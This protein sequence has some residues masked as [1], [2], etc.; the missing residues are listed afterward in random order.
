MSFPLAASGFWSG[1]NEAVSGNTT[2]FQGA[3]WLDAGSSSRTGSGTDLTGK[4]STL[5]RVTLQPPLRE[6]IKVVVVDKLHYL[7]TGMLINS[8]Y[9]FLL[10][11]QYPLC[12]KRN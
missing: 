7:L 3:K 8:A 5:F 4:N 6:G 10:M 12:V 11:K 1:R 2:P 9:R